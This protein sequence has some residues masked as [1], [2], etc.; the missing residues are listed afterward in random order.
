MMQ[1]LQLLLRDSPI[2]W[3]VTWIPVQAGVLGNVA[4]DG[5]A[6]R[7]ARASRE[8]RGLAD[9]VLDLRIRNCS[10]VTRY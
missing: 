6:T 10:I 4:A 8:G 9:L 2:H 3:D 7:G 5:A 1:A